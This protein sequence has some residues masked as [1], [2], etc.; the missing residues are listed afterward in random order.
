M[1]SRSLRIAV[2]NQPF[3]PIFLVGISIAAIGLLA[4]FLTGAL[5]AIVRQAF[6]L[7]P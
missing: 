6:G 7:A 1:S 5:Q 4:S 3:G 2:V